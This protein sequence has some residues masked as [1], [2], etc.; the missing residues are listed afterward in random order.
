[1]YMIQIFVNV[2]LQRCQL[3]MFVSRVTVATV[4]AVVVG[5]R[6]LLQTEGTVMLHVTFALKQDQVMPVCC[7][8][9]CVCVYVCVCVC[10]CVCVCVCV[11]E[12]R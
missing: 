10:M 11:C 7:V 6:E 2:V 1:M 4:M 9:V 12:M 3:C 5:Q 8:C